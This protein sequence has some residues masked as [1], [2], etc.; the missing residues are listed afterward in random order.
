VND[1]GGTAVASDWTLFADGLSVTGS[2]AGAEVTD[3]AG[4]YALSESALAGYANTSIT[5]DNADGEV[6]SVTVGLGETVTCTFVN[7]DDAATIV[8]RKVVVG[9]PASQADFDAFIDQTGVAW[10]AITMI[11]PGDYTASEIM[12][13]ADY[14]AGEWS[15]DCDADGAFSIELGDA[16]ECTIT[17]FHADIEITKTAE[18]GFYAEVGDV[19]SYTIT[20]TNTGSATLSNVDIADNFPGGLDGWQCTPAEPATLAPGESIVCTATHTITEADIEAGQVYNQACVDTDQ[21]SKPVCDDETVLLSELEI[22]KEADVDW[23]SAAGD[24]IN[25]TITATNTGQSALTNV[26]ISD[27]LFDDLEN[28]VCTPPLVVDELQPGESIVCTASYTITGADI[29]AG[30]V[31]NQACVDSDETPEVCDDVTT[32]HAELEI[33]KSATPDT[34]SA[35]G[36]EI[37]YTV[38]ATNTGQATLENVDISDELIDGLD[39]WTCQVGDTEVTLPV[40]ELLSGQSIVCTATYTITDNDVTG[41]E[42]EGF[43][44]NTA[45]ADSDQ[46]PEVCDEV[47][48]NEIVIELIKSVTPTVLPE[49]GG[50]FTYTLYIDNESVVPLEITE[51]VDDN[52]ALSPDWAANCAVLVGQTLAP[53]AP[54]T[55]DEVTCTYTVERTVAGTYPNTAQV[56]GTDANGREARA[57]D[58]VSVRVLRSELDIVKEADVDTYSA[59]G[60]E[61][62]Y[63]VTATN[64]GESTLTNVDISDE[65]IDGLASW[66]CDPGNPVASLAP[67]ESIVCTATYI[68]TQA[69]IDAGTVFNQAC[70]DSDLTPEVCDDVTVLLAELEIVK[71]A[72]VEYYTG[73][74][75]EIVYTVTATNTG[76][77]T[78]TNVDISDELIDGLASWTCDPGNPV[79]SLAPGASITCTAVYTITEADIE[80]GTVFNQACV[81]SDEFGSEEEICDEVTIRDIN[82]TITKTPDQDIVNSGDEV[83]FTLV[84]RHDVPVTMAPI[85][86]HSLTDSDFGDLFHA[87]NTAVTDNTCPAGAGELLEPD[88]DYTCEFTATLTGSPNNPHENIATIVVTDRAEVD[89][90]FAQASDPA[91]VGFLAVSPTPLPTPTPNPSLKPTD[92]LLPTDPIEPV[93]DGAGSGGMLGWAVWVL[94]S[95]LL[96]VGS[97]W[98]IR[99]QRLA[100]VRTR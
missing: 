62:G 45:C 58:D 93:D 52:S 9:G 50:T 17:N 3:V 98:V 80:A 65:L 8:L 49:P 23:Y 40:A 57:E 2:E 56:T 53:D 35:V 87:G 18:P 89:P 33:E 94:L 39:S 60:D 86:A 72:S 37:V 73:A 24:V 46:T 26:D 69:D 100:E 81:V 14:V 61:I 21:T 55:A 74:G 38:I 16:L 66:T 28:W 77:A 92:M 67:G 30:Q 6:T 36:D 79:A 19:V 7:D 29:E 15:G 41:S 68:I 48:V 11:V 84:Y 83:T 32:P 51:L 27:N 1:N 71:A 4:T 59:V 13:V 90:R 97:G 82:V 70:V 22:V 96:I 63:T 25:Y 78:L 42:P 12:N 91:V 31:F 5:C 88:T 95:A 54:G 76:E 85:Y 64:T 34:Y 20:A 75:E 47:T 43:V 10:G 99:R 44:V